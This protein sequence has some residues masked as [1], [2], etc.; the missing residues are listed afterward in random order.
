MGSRL[1]PAL[2][3]PASAALV[4]AMLAGCL[5]LWVV[6]PL[7]WLWIGSQVEASASL[8]AGLAVAMAGALATIVLGAMGLARMDRLHRRLRRPPRGGE[9]PSVLEAILVVSA[10]LAAAL[11]A[12]W[13]LFFAGTSPVPLNISY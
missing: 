10:A 2:R 5:A 12:A 4:L 6:V 11:F 9:A 8:G 7:G 3:A 1:P 13:F